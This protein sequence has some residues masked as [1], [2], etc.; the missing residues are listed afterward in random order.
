MHIATFNF[1]VHFREKFVLRAP[2]CW[3]KK[4]SMMNLRRNWWRKQKLGWLVILLILKFNKGLRYELSSTIM[5]TFVFS[6]DPLTIETE[7]RVVKI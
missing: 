2:V 5:S 4:E 3:F 7:M 6:S 1:L